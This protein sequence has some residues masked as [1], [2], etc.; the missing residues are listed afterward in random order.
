MM[1]CRVTVTDDIVMTLFPDEVAPMPRYIIERNTGPLTRD[2]LDAAGR[3]SNQ[4]LT[5]MDGVTWIRSYVSHA[6]GKIFCEYEAPNAELIRE[7][8]RRAGLPADAVRE[9]ELTIS[10]DMFR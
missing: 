3:R 8:A 5:E 10:P 1:P 9:I 6:D 2:E 4:V 7:H